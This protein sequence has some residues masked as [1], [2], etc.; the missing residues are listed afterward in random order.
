VVIFL[1]RR[2]RKS[3][4]RQQALALRRS[5][6]SIDLT[7]LSADIEARVRSLNEYSVARTIASYVAKPDEVQT[8]S[9][10][11]HSLIA[12]K[13]V[14]V[15]KTDQLA[16]RLIFSELRDP[17]L[18][19]APGQM[20][21]LEPRPD[22]LRP[23]DLSEAALVLVPVVAWDV[24]GYR[25]GYGRGYFDRALAGLDRGVVTIGLALELQRFP[26]LPIEKHD[27]PLRMIITEKR[28][29]VRT[30]GECPS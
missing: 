10:I 22:H 3:E 13:R 29:I 25:L 15:P 7:R 26:E 17:H 11:R 6:P 18:D 9:L 4:M 28:V 21:I 14:L 1:D 12:G 19:L 16:R 30:G 24:R 5:I 27:V 20:G 2:E 8:E 23:V